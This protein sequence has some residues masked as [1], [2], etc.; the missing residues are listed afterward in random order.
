MEVF[1]EIGDEEEAD[2]VLLRIAIAARHVGDLERAV[3]L[4]SEA[5][6]RI[7]MRGNRR[8][9]AM[10]LYNLAMV[11]FDRGDRPRALD[12]AHESASVSESIDFTWWRGVTLF[13][14]SERLIQAGDLEAAKPEFREG[15][16][17]LAAVPDL[18]NLPIALA[19]GA[20][21]AAAAGEAVRAGTLWGAVETAGERDPRPT[22]P[23]AL[24]EYAPFV[25]SVL[26]ADFERGRA[27]GRTLSL[28]DA[29]EFALDRR[30]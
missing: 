28:E 8:D 4:T 20:A 21:I 15:L 18:V 14:T 7:R 27:R 29:V 22:T 5:L 23:E 10:A 1:R 9:E 6:E 3:R 26:G 12:L 16:A 25:E 24:R 11:A 2:H 13:A 17:A 30:A 19:A